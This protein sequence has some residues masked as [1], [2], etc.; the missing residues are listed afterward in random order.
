MK[1]RIFVTQLS[2]AT[3]ENKGILSRA[4]NLIKKK[5]LSRPKIVQCILTTR[6]IFKT[7]LFVAEL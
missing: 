7:K 3:V 4:Y 2:I 1:Q 6:I 5:Q